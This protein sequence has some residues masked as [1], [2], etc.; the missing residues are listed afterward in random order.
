MEN[1]TRISKA[2]ISVCLIFSMLS[3]LFIANAESTG[4]TATQGLDMSMTLNQDGNSLVNANGQTVRLLGTNVPQ[5]SWSATGENGNVKKIMELALDEWQSNC[6]RLAVV[7]HF[8]LHGD[9]DEVNGAQV[10]TTTAAQYRALV[11]ELINMAVARGKYVILDNHSFYL[12]GDDSIEFWQSAAVIYKDHPNVIFGVFNEPANCSWD[13]WYKGGHIDFKGVNDFGQEDNVSIDSKGIPYLTTVIRS[14]GA[15]NLM[16]IGGLNWGFD[17]TRVVDDCRIEDTTGNGIMFESHPY[18]WRDT[19]W[20]TCIGRAANEYPI[21]FGECGP[22]NERNF[23]TDDTAYMKKMCNFMDKYEINLT[24]WALGAEPNLLLSP[25]LVPTTYGQIIKDYI[26]KNQAAKSVTLYSGTDLTGSSVSLDPGKYTATDLNAKGFNLSDIA[27]IDS[28][29]NRYQYQITLY[30]NDDYTGSSYT[31]ISGST[32]LNGK[33]EFTPKSVKLTRSLPQNIIV[34]NAEV[35]VS[36]GENPEYLI[37]GKDK[38]V[39]TNTDE[40]GSTITIKLDKPYSLTNIVLDHAGA[41]GMMSMFNTADY[42][43]S[44]STDGVVYTRVA[45]IVGNNL[46]T[47]ENRFDQVVASYIK[48]FI[49]KGGIIEGDT[50]YLSEVKAYGI[51]YDGKIEATPT[52]LY[53]V[54]DINGMPAWS[55]VAI[56]LIGVV[57]ILS[58]GVLYMFKFRKPKSE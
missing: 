43:I 23:K 2:I 7:P 51:P 41:S 14:T 44:L 18:P 35:T 56:I 29:Y 31:V 13:Q 54:K 36:G 15:K 20:D 50:A 22:T 17:L 11:D 6:V 21:M 3:V 30:E 58:A 55:I 12:P 40:N 38:T 47:T 24:A 5:L 39:W 46:G 10:Q 19:D 48:I 1:L 25:K 42:S 33:Y 45:D 16:S 53:V 52:A 28:K 32:S 27:S 9:F 8:W 34:G 57:L 37:D 26:A 4:S 49:K